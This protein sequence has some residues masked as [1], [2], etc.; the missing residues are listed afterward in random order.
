VE[1]LMPSP[2]KMPKKP[3]EVGAY[4]SLEERV[5]HLEKSIGLLWQAVFVL[6][7]RLSP[8]LQGGLGA[9]C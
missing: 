1:I 3:R 8:E 7:E 5:A 9:Y 2:K 6:E 4:A